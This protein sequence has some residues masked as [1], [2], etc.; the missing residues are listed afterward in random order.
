M[1]THNEVSPDEPLGA[2]GKVRVD[3]ASLMN[4][5]ETG[6][7]LNAWPMAAWAHLEA[8]ASARRRGLIQSMVLDTVFCLSCLRS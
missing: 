6:P 1:P 5:L 8:R 7:V 3:V 2:L 4:E